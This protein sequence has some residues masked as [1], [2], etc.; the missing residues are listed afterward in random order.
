[1]SISSSVWVFNEADRQTYADRFWRLPTRLVTEG[2]LAELWREAGTRRG[3]G[4]VTSLLPAL[5]LDTWPG[6][7]GAEKEWTGPT[8]VPNQRLATLAGIS[9]DSVTA[10]C[11]RLVER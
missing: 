2:L 4:I 5:A 10:A 6:Q 9:R 1:M 11:R 7:V 8:H 3:G